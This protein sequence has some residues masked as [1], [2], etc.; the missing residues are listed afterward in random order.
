MLIYWLLSMP[1]HTLSL[2]DQEITQI[3]EKIF[4][5]ECASKKDCLVA[6]NDG[7]YFA[8][9]GIGHFIWYPKNVQGPFEESFPALLK[10]MKTQ[11]ITLPDWLNGNSPDAPWHDKKQFLAEFQNHQTQQLIQFLHET[12]K[13]QIA[14]I[15]QRLE[16]ALPKLLKVIEPTQQDTIRNRFEQLTNSAQGLYA[17][18]DYVNFKGE[19]TN[20]NERY[21]GQGWGLLQVLQTMDAKQTEL[22]INIVFSNAAE[23]VLRQ[24]VALAPIERNEQRWLAGWLKR[25]QTY[26]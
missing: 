9:L 14:F 3:G 21:Q 11:H 5:N 23:K 8:S 24:R 13:V 20:P 15:V 1:T 16:Q 19:G 26:R 17:L 25:I 12:K 7:E 6:W 18:I 22:P 10:F 4:H 2:S